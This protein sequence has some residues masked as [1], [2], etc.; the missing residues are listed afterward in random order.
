MSLIQS[1][2]SN[3]RVLWHLLINRVRGTTHEQRLESFYKGQAGDYDGFRKRLLHGR[4]EM[5]DSIVFP[6]NGIWVDL[7]A[8]T[9]ANAEHVASTIPRLKHVY[10]VDL[11]QPL[12]DVAGTRVKNHNWENV[13]PVHADATTFAP[14]EGLAD[15]VTF[16]YSLTMIPDWF[17]AIDNAFRMLK[18]GGVIGI[19][20]FYVARKYPADNMV[21]HPWSTRTF[22]TTWFA[23]DNVFM[24]GDHLPY[25]RH[26]FEQLNLEE[27]R[28]KVPFMPLI[29]APHYLFLGRKPE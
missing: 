18:P 9:G 22:W 11:C 28:G 17:A 1:V 23:M 7:G 29:R 13:T 12:L 26:K 20:D 3:F 6:D 10:Q 8:G 25:L 4:E 27:R 16:S 5:L 2:S 24:N 15:V 19:V 21:K 14:Q